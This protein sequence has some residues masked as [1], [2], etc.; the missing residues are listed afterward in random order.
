[1]RGDARER[2]YPVRGRSELLRVDWNAADTKTRGD[3]ERSI[4]Q[5]RRSIRKAQCT[6]NQIFGRLLLLRERRAH[7]ELSACQELRRSW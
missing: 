3:I 1:M 2:E 4:R 5:F 7:A 6:E